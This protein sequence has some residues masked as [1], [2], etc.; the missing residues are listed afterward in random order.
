MI[1]ISTTK[2]PDLQ[3]KGFPL[4]QATIGKDGILRISGQLP[5]DPATGKLVEGGIVQQTEQIMRNL[6]AILHE[7]GCNFDNV[8][9]SICWLK[10]LN[11]SEGFNKVYGNYFHDGFPAR[12]AYG[13]AQIA[14]GAL[15]EISMEAEVPE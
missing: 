6:E 7:A 15:A 11:I 5:I 14:M 13:G 4:C 12:E 8:L 2:A 1:R 9:K 10:D 3:E